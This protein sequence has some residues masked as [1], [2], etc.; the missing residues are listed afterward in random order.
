MMFQ[1]SIVIMGF[2]LESPDNG[3]IAMKYK[4]IQN[5]FP[6]E[7]DLCG[8]IKFGKCSD[9]EA[10]LSQIISDVDVTDN[11]I[12][13]TCDS[14]CENLKAFFFKNGKLEEAQYEVLSEEELQKNFTFVRLRFDMREYVDDLSRIPEIMQ[15]RR[16][17]V[18]LRSHG[19]HYSDSCK[20]YPS[21]PLDG[22]AS[23]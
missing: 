11:P 10:H 15:E 18:R 12:L 13:L 16:K 3:G 21:W 6:T 4:Q 19:S 22:C 2:N 5:K 20:S 1:G 7:V 14:G 9:V 23:A 8:L 17:Y